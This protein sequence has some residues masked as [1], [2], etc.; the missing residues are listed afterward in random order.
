MRFLSFT[1]CAR[2]PQGAT[3]P[4]ERVM[5]TLFV[6]YAAP[7]VVMAARMSRKASSRTIL[8]P[9]PHQRLEVSCGDGG[10]LIYFDAAQLGEFC[11]SPGQI[12]GLVTLAAAR[13]GREE[14]RIGFD[15]HGCERQRLCGI[16]D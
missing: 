6:V 14:W 15:Q 16:A 11:R 8:A 13:D 3:Q 10:Q 9:D 1:R 4:W 12:C 2:R 7:S 5:V